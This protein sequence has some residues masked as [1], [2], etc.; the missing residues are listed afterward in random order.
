MLKQR[1]EEWIY[2]HVHLYADVMYLCSYVHI[3]IHIFI[4]FYI[5]A[6]VM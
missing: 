2:A 4:V 1:V 3:D 6:I 5:R